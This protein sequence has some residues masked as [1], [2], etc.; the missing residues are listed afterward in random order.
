M[1]WK[2]SVTIRSVSLVAGVLLVSST[3]ALAQISAAHHFAAIAARSDHSIQLALTGAEPVAARNYYDIFPIETSLDLTGWQPLITLQRTNNLTNTVI[4]SDADAAGL[5]RRF[6]RTPTNQLTT[7][8][9]P[10][11]GPYAVG[12]VSQLLTNS[13]RNILYSGTNR[14]FMVSIWYPAQVVTGLLPAVYIDPK[15]AALGASFCITGNYGGM[16]SHALPQA[17]VATNEAS[18]PVVIYSHGYQ[19]LRTDNTRK[20][21]NLASFGFVVVALDHVDTKATVLPDGSLLKGVVAPNLS[22][23]DPLTLQIATN[24]VS[25]IK[26]LVDQISQWNVSD[27]LLHGRLDFNNVGIFGHSF[28]GGTS[29]GSCAQVTGIK[30]G[31]SLDGGWPVIPIPAF[32]KPFLILSGGDSDPNMQTFR[33]SYTNL[34]AHLSQ[35]AYY[36]H[37]TNSAHCDFN[38][39]PWFDS[40]TSATLIRRALVQDLYTVSFFRKYL[41]GEDDHFLDAKPIDWPEVDVYLKK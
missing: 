17:P 23:G 21:E 41:R 12:V 27:P 20:A 4:Y 35:D 22:P 29:A 5:A 18:Y 3:R 10:P 13:S 15:I 31:L 36:A 34:F 6:Y 33:A 16:H 11:G 14:S 7:A 30:A 28:G 19:T 25:D 32:D 24:R 1:C 37:L 38:E 8:L 40:P 9:P 26:F 2:H 39:T